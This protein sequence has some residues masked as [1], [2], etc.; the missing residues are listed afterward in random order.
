MWYPEAARYWQEQNLEGYGEGLVEEEQASPQCLACCLGPA[1]PRLPDARQQRRQALLIARVPLD[2]ADLQHDRQL[3]SVYKGLTGTTTDVPPIGRHWEVRTAAHRSLLPLLPCWR[4][5]ALPLSAPPPQDIGF[6]GSDPATDLRSGGMLT[7]LLVLGLIHEDA[8]SARRALRL[9]QDDVQHFPFMAV[10]V[11]ITL[12]CMAALRSGRL[13]GTCEARGSVLAGV[14]RLYAALWW[15][16]HTQWASRGLTVVDFH[17]IKEEMAAQA[18][19]PAALVKRYEAARAQ[20]TQGGGT[21]EG[22]N[23]SFVE[24]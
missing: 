14:T 18:R 1:L 2:R 22:D 8:P 6:Q 17:A 16:M 23:A 10:A 20:R 21:V 5:G 13:A 12:L 15:F 24:C 7:V 4:S 3:Q 11:N 19:Q 9:S